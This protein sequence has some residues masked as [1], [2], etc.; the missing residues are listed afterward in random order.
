MDPIASDKIATEGEAA[1][2]TEET[3]TDEAARVTLEA[4][5]ADPAN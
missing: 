1:R 4:R 3:R 2:S 5:P